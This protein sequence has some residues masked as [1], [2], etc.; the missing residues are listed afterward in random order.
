VL[1]SSSES[2]AA[3]HAETDRQTRWQWL[4]GL[5]AAAVAQSW[6]QKRAVEHDGHDTGVATPG[7]IVIYLC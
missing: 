5:A 2:P 1:W 4:A 3:L 7:R 6:L